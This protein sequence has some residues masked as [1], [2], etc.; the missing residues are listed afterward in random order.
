[1]SWRR[2][3]LSALRLV[4]LDTADL[5]A[6]GQVVSR[7]GEP[8]VVALDADVHVVS[9]GREVQ[10]EPLARNAWLVQARRAGRRLSSRRLSP[11]AWI[12]ERTGE[13]GAQVL[14]LG[15]KSTAAY[16]V[17][18]R[19]ATRR[20]FRRWELGLAHFVA[21]E[22]AAW[23]LR[24]LD[25]N[26]VLDVGAN[27]GQYAGALREAGYRGRIV[28]F[29]PLPHLVA[30]VERRAAADPDWMV[31]PVALGDEDREAEI[32]VV[33][34]TMSSMLGSS[35]FGRSWAPVLG[36]MKPQPITVRRLDSLLDEALSG[37]PD[38]RVYLKMDT[39]GYDVQTFKG[40]GARIGEIV[41]M[42]SE[43]ACV[44]IY[45]GMPEMAEQLAL[46]QS[47]GFAL[48]GT[49]PVT[50]DRRTLR[51]IEFDAMFVRPEALADRDR[52]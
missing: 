32:N 33:P 13:G 22:H 30:E 29:E 20:R 5:G 40:A 27:Q 24:E 36:T 26:C 50:I 39:Q 41:G 38:P 8:G 17:H 45:D 28:S 16:L 42:Q 7:G 43:I 3:L 6:S 23:M 9:G 18:D 1:M 47:A 11:R 21:V 4:G 15:P 37:L 35:E 46:Y 31:V 12:V 19:E 34:G 14:R 49:F 2:R 25:V 51:I 48:S 10:S 52:H 44:P